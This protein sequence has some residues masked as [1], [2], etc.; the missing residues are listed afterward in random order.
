[1]TRPEGFLIRIQLD[2][3]LRLERGIL[4]L[5]FADFVC[6][7]F[8]ELLL[9]GKALLPSVCGCVYVVSSLCVNRV[10]SLCQ[11]CPSHKLSAGLL[12]SVSI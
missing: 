4:G 12:P 7:Y 8:K 1:M 11:S 10:F 6:L 9:G 5:C 3:L 2:R